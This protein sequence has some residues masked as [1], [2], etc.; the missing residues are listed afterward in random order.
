MLKQLQNPNKVRRN[1]FLHHMIELDDDR[2]EFDQERA[3]EILLPF[4]E[5]PL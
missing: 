4:A 3:T 5:H 1:P 2:V